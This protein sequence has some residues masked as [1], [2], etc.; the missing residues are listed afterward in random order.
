MKSRRHIKQFVKSFLDKNPQVIEAYVSAGINAIDYALVPL[1]NVMKHLLV[2]QGLDPNSQPG[3][4]QR[5]AL[6]DALFTSFNKVDDKDYHDNYD[7]SWAHSRFEKTQQ[8]LSNLNLSQE[9]FKKLTDLTSIDS[10]EQKYEPNPFS[11]SM[12][13]KWDSVVLNEMPMNETKE[14][15][16]YFEKNKKHINR[17]APPSPLRKETSLEENVKENLEKTKRMIEDSSIDPSAKKVMKAKA[18]VL[19]QRTI[20]PDIFEEE[21]NSLLEIPAVNEVAKAFDPRDPSSFVPALKM[22]VETLEAQSV[23]KEKERTPV[24]VP[25]TFTKEK[26]DL[27][28]DLSAEEDAREAGQKQILSA[29]LKR[30]SANKISATLEDPIK[31]NSFRRSK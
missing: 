8:K 30:T 2:V 6:Q 26:E 14:E 15:T 21:K 27:T 11:Q 5:K 17:V 9:A 7:T 3:D 16:E 18:E 23:A 1:N 19:A 4:R 13:S 29:K 20:N 10:P 22:I 12:A 31:K 25:S 28:F 24:K